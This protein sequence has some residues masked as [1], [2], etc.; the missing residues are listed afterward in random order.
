MYQ[1]W[2]GLYDTDVW[3]LD[4]LTSALPDNWLETHP[5]GQEQSWYIIMLWDGWF[6]TCC[7]HQT[8][9]MAKMYYLKSWSNLNLHFRFCLFCLKI[10]T[11]LNSLS[12]LFLI[13]S[14]VYSAALADS[15]LGLE[16]KMSLEFLILLPWPPQCWDYNH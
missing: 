16:T 1:K 6:V 4:W 8:L 10:F 15:K 11:S 2:K 7:V 13:F 14:F 9:H 5:W 3:I 12:I